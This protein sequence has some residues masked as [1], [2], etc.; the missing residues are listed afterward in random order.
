MRHRGERIEQ[1]RL[2]ALARAAR[3]PDA[4]VTR[5]SARGTRPRCRRV[6]GHGHVE[7]HVARHR[8]VA[9][10]SARKRSRIGL[11]S[12]RRYRRGW[13]TPSGRARESARSVARERSERRAL[14]STTGTPR[15][16]HSS[17]Q[18]RPHLGLEHDAQVAGGSARGNAAP[19]IPWSYGS[20][21]RS[22]RSPK[23]SSPVARPVGVMWVM[24]MRWPGWLARERLDHRCRG[25]RL[26][27]GDRVDPDARDASA[28]ARSGRSARRCARDSRAAGARATSSRA[29]T[30]GVRERPREG[31]ERG[32]SC[33][34][35]A[36]PRARSD[37]RRPRAR[38]PGPPRFTPFAPC[39]PGELGPRGAVDADGGP[40]ERHR[41]V[42]E[43]GV[44]ADHERRVGD[45][46][47]D[48][49]EA[50]RGRRDRAG[51]GRGEARGRRA[52]A[53]ASRREARTRCR[54]RRGARRASIQ[55]SSGQRFVGA[56][57]RVQQHR[58]GPRGRPR[59]RG[60]GRVEPVARRRPRAGSRRP[61]PPGR[62][63][64]PRHGA[65]AAPG[66]C[67]S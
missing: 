51:N 7:L 28:P 23:S 30:S 8:D 5:R 10:P 15:A 40:P 67:T 59:R 36:R 66:C 58:V 56:A 45:Q 31:V 55:R 44:D 1:Q 46:R 53:V 32:A 20:H 6:R 27:H 22:T 16:R 12:G 13:R 29:S 33:P 4:R 26:A 38:C 61:S 57:R 21:A 54:R 18:A 24:R 47:R 43:P 50:H 14:A 48:L 52:L 39:R 25:A 49:R 63:C 11:R 2:L 65:R 35:G 34:G 60:G 37:G 41:E 62:D 64:A 17:Q 19:R 3:D 9:R 42:R